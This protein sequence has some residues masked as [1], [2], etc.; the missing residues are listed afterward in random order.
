MSAADEMRAVDN[1]N[2]QERLPA[3]EIALMWLSVAAIAGAIHWASL[4]QSFNSPDNVMRLVEVRAFLAGAPWFDPHEARIDPPHGY[5]THW[6]R[7]IDGGLAGLIVLF[8]LI[9]SPDLAERLARCAWPLLLSGPAIAASAAA[10]VRLSGAMAGRA[11]LL[12]ALLVLIA[13]PGHF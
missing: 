7:L 1:S 13:M 9:A 3:T 4:D 11:T 10:A 5:D 6:S 8:R 2:G 12:S